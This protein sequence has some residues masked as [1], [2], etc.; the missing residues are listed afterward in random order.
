MKKLF[1][2]TVAA[3]ALG[4]IAIS[5][6]PVRVAA[7]SQQDDETIS[8]IKI[9]N[10]RL[11]EENAILRE[12]VQLRRE[13]EALRASLKNQEQPS[14]AIQ[15]SPT[16]QPN[17]KIQSAQAAESAYAADM[18]SRTPIYK[19]EPLV[20]RSSWDGFYLGLGI[21]SRWTHTDASVESV[22]FGNSPS[23]N[24]LGSMDIDGA[25]F[26]F[27]PYLGYNWQVSPK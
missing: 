17:P 6:S 21:G 1:V 26:R 19:A 4:T 14:P 25:S 2:G 18:H 22:N 16:K 9:E 24:A 10:A 27:S 11:R 12:R 7:A 13:N 23:P 3:F 20:A 5:L 15:S 8:A